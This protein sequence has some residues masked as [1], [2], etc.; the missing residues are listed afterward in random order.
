MQHAEGLKTGTVLLQR[1]E[2][3]GSRAA[4]KGGGRRS[5]WKG[6]EGKSV[7]CRRQTHG[8]AKKGQS[9]YKTGR[10]SVQR[11]GARLEG[12]K[13]RRQ[14]GVS[15]ERKGGGLGDSSRSTAQPGVPSSRHSRSRQQPTAATEAPPAAPKQA[16]PRHPGEGVLAAAAAAAARYQAAVFVM[17]ERCHCARAKIRGASGAIGGD[18]KTREGHQHRGVG[19]WARY[20]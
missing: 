20:L 14:E 7:P 6:R 4:S 18:F 1:V 16:H 9:L 12:V 3:A 5:K 13:G 8:G 17:C 15:A 11:V 10:T 19:G 2:D